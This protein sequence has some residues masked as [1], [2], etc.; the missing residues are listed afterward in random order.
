[1]IRE[2]DINQNVHTN[3]FVFIYFSSFMGTSKYVIVTALFALASHHI[4]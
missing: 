1:V 2:K 4:N 3:Y